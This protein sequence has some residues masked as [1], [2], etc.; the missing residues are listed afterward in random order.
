[1]TIKKIV[2]LSTAIAASALAGV[3]TFGPPAGAHDA[4]FK[5][6]MRTPSGESVGTVK[7]RVSHHAMY[8]VARLR[9]PEGKGLDRNAF[10]G[11]HIH[12]NNVGD[13]NGCKADPDA[14][15]TTWF[16]SADGH[17]S[18]PGINHGAH[19]GDLPSPLVMADGTVLLKFSTDRIKPADLRGRAVILHAKPDNFNNIP[20]GSGPT[21]YT[22]N[23]QTAALDLT[24]RTGNAGDRVAC[25]VIKST[26]W[27]S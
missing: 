1:M 10:H 25:G 13:E 23:D 24:N 14:E 9:L 22:P 19:K 12:A 18:D 21:Q 20:V 11:F 2:A 17:L 26:G 7:F 8:V 3:L 4:Q 16:V 15:S 6:T 27:R 5:A